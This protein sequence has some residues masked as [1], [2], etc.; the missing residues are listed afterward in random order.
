[1]KTPVR[2]EDEADAAYREAGRWYNARRAGLGVEFF[3]E[4][5]ATI[6]PILDLP[7]SGVRMRRLPTEL[8]IREPL[9]NHRSA[10][11][12]RCLPSQRPLCS[13]LAEIVCPPNACRSAAAFGVHREN[14]AEAL[15][16]SRLFGG[17]IHASSPGAQARR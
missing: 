6:K 5:D 8:P 1:M 17:V 10:P 13:G 16:C 4:V 12:P 2:F 7:N 3:D 9:A 14:T 15:G 11:M